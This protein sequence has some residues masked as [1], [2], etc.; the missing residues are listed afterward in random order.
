MK[1]QILFIWWWEDLQNFQNENF[2]NLKIDF[3][4]NNFDFNPFLEKQNNW[5][6]YLSENLSEDFDF[7]KMYR[8]DC[9]YELWKIS[10][11]KTLNF[12]WDDI[13]LIGHSLWSI[14]ILKYFSENLLNIKKI[15]KILL[16]STPLNDSKEEILWSFNLDKN[17]LKNLYNFQENIVF[18]HSKDDNIV[19][20][21]DF[22]EYKQIFKKSNFIELDWYWHFV[23]NQTFPELLEKIKDI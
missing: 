19:S 23:L 10:F 7:I 3:F 1:K 20:Y 13:I 14:F 8:P 22:L 5:K 9:I 16:I 4:R 11:E 2:V 18:F 12:L 6:D 21:S 15:T 17:L